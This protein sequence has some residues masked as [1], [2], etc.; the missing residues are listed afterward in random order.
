MPDHIF[1]INTK[2]ATVSDINFVIQALKV[3]RDK[4]S[5]P[6]FEFTRNKI[7]PAIDRVILELED[8]TKQ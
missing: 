5:Q 4:H 8:M 2:Y 3:L 7:V 6:E 1:S